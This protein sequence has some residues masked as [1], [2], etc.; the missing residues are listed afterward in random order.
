VKRYCHGLWSDERE[1]D[2]DEPLEPFL[3][4]ER[5]LCSRLAGEKL[6][7]LGVG[8]EIIRYHFLHRPFRQARVIYGRNDS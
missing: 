3:E 8:E 4:Q 6:D 7:H 2:L 1:L 5:G